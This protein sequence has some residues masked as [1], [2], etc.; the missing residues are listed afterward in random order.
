MSAVPAPPP[1]VAPTV[2]SSVLATSGKTRTGRSRA[3]RSIGRLNDDDDS[4]LEDGFAADSIFDNPDTLDITEQDKL[5]CPDSP[6]RPR[7]LPSPT[8]PDDPCIKIMATFY[9]E[10]GVEQVRIPDGRIITRYE[11]DQ[12]VKIGENYQLLQSLGL[13]PGGDSLLSTDGERARALAELPSL[14]DDFEMPPPRSNP[15]RAAKAASSV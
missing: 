3:R 2:S 14:P 15:A 6:I 5:T 8:S 10:D 12:L 13:H 4:D 1:P 9:R 7:P 11:H